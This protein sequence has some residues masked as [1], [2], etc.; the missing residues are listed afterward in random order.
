[1]EAHYVNLFLC[2]IEIVLNGKR[3]GPECSNLV[4]RWLKWLE[5]LS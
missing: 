5:K 3:K 2:M 4:G 1:M